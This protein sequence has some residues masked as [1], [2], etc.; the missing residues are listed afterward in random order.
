MLYQNSCITDQSYIYCIFINF[1]AQPNT[2]KITNNKRSLNDQDLFGNI[3][4]IN[5]EDEECKFSN[6]YLYNHLN[7]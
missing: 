3:D 2:L 7:L 4:D 6:M 1:Q 5:F